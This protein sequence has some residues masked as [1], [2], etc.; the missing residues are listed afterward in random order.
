MER[1]DF[2]EGIAAVY[3]YLRYT[4][5]PDNQT[6]NAWFEKCSF[7]PG[8]AFIW[9]IESLESSDTLP[10]NM[11]KSIIRLWYDYQKQP[12]HGV[13]EIED[14]EDCMGRGF[15]SFKK[16]EPELG[17]EVVYTANCGL[18]KNKYFGSG[19]KIAT[20]TAAQILNRGWE[21]L[22]NDAAK[23]TGMYIN[24]DQIEEIAN[25]AIKDTPF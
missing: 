18:C 19:V 21:L 3:R 4:N 17:Y 8:P 7:I 9:I 13:R 6:L 16:F 5:I 15:L 22:P 20:F 14:C 25:G 23:N 11:P 1:K 10:R 24:K 2:T 12:G